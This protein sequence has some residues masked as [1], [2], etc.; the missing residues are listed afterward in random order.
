MKKI[1][2]VA[3][4]VAM[5]TTFA[6]AQSGAK[7]VMK[8][9]A[10]LFAKTLTTTDS[11]YHNIDSFYINANEAGILE[12][13]VV[14][15]DRTGVLGITGDLKIRYV[16]SAG[17]I[18]LGTPVADM[19]LVIDSGLSPGTFNFYASGTKIYVRVKGALSTDIRW[20]ATLKRN[21][22]YKTS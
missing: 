3:M 11:N 4:L 9:G 1:L 21:S 7:L 22:V 13:K 10:E 19:A 18:T 5:A 14:A 6:A 12:A 16:S 2:C 17:T 8:N 20:Y 15:L